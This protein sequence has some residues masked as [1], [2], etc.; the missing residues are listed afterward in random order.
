MTREYT[1][2]CPRVG[3]AAFVKAFSDLATSTDADV[4]R[5]THR[6][7]VVPHLPEEALGYLHMPHEMWQAD[8]TDPALTDCAD[9]ATSED[10]ACSNSCSPFS[11][12]S[13]ADHLS[14]LGLVQGINGC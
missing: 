9:S 1:Y 14:Y 10:D 13:K 6:D 8:A 12:V 2:G 5:V 7:D 3:D 11:C 4:Y